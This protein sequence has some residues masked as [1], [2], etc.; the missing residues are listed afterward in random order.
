MLQLFY[1]II[2]VATGSGAFPLISIIMIAATY[3]LQV[4]PCSSYPVM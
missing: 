2:T 3:G 4:S 1:L